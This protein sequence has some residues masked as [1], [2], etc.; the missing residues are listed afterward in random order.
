[1][2]L[3]A[4][5][6]GLACR[7]PEPL[8]RVTV[9]GI[10]T[11]A[12]CTV[13]P[14]ADHD[15]WHRLLAG[16]R[17]CDDADTAVGDCDPDT[18]DLPCQ[19]AGVDVCNGVDDDC[20]G[21]ADDP[22]LT[23]VTGPASVAAVGGLG[24]DG[25]AVF[26]VGE[27]S[28]VP[29]VEGAVA[30][31][32]LDGRL[33]VRIYGTG[34]SPSFGSQLAT[35]R[36]LSGD[37]VDDLVVAAP[38][39]TT[40]DGPNSGRVFVFAGPLA[41]TT[42]LAD[43]VG[44]F[45]GGELDGQPGGQLALAPDLD[46]DGLA[47]LVIGYYR[48]TLFFSGAP[49]L[50]ARRA[51]AFLDLELNTGGGA[52]H[53]AS[54]PDADG[55]GR[56]ELLIGMD[57]YDGGAGLVAMI[58]SGAPTALARTW[59]DARWPG[60]G[61]KLVVVGDVPWALSGNTPVRVDRFESLPFE[62][63]SLGDGGDVDGDG[64]ADLLVE[65]ASGIIVPGLREVPFAGRLQGERNLASATD[66]DGDGVPE[67]RLLVED[68][69]AVLSGARAF[70]AP[71]D[72][73]GDGISGAAGDCDD[74]D[75]TRRPFA[76]DIAD[77]VDQDCD[78]EVDVPLEQE[79]PVPRAVA[80]VDVV[81]FAVDAGMVLGADGVATGYGDW[82]ATS[83][84]GLQNLAWGGSSGGAGAAYLLGHQDAGAALLP[85][86]AFGAPEFVAVARIGDA[87]GLA[88]TGALGTPGDF[89]GDGIDELVV[90]AID[91]GG[92]PTVGL[93]AGPVAG[94][95]SLDDAAWL[96]N[97]PE[98]W[99]N[100]TLALLNGPGATDVNGDGLADLV[101]G[102][103]AAYFGQGR[104]SVY[105]ALRQGTHEADQVAFVDWYGEPEEALGS[106]LA[107]GVD[108]TGDGLL[109]ALVG[110][111]RGPRVLAG[112]ACPELV[113]ILAA[114]SAWLALVDVDGDGDVE[115]LGGAEGWLWVDGSPWRQASAL[116]SAGPF[117]VAYA[118]GEDAWLAPAP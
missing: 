104:V 24:P 65:T 37:G 57:T 94:D 77:G 38:F 47:E 30:V 66:L 74:S 63:V 68:G 16:G 103:A 27:A 42:T 59:S 12:G 41:A 108:L 64:H 25:T 112:G 58:E 87:P 36:D 88:R 83:V 102:S 86:G 50:A 89:D 67:L 62:A 116:W 73:D 69:A 29:G 3:F 110:G 61:A 72:V 9:P 13:T 18:G 111:A 80:V 99:T 44:W 52:W 53:Y 32:G 20:N 56:A 118:D 98:G 71:C 4:L 19:P 48:H 8:G 60:L 117:G 70:V 106:T 100:P 96:V 23:R 40:D 35:G 17:D 7:V 11:P 115:P 79:L 39:A 54:L 91:A 45:E 81:P 75:P 10:E 107:A 95:Q 55:D 85:R 33:L 105:S 22:F 92:H 76:H 31:Y 2:S 101:G 34:Q 97:L 51:D 6:L 84:S 14:D 43:A 21:L 15:N 109:D 114:P 46:G 90:M 49:G 82:S 26:V 78:G 28:A 1:M 113:G 93:F 5:A